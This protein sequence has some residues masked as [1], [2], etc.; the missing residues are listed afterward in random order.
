MPAHQLLPNGADMRLVDIAMDMKFFSQ[1]ISP[2]A[3]R[4]RSW[5]YTEPL[6]GRK[7]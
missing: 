2:R 7:G 6:C 5:L 4:R 1:S 3:Y